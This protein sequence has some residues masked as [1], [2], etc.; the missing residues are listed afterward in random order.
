[1]VAQKQKEA[2]AAE[3]CIVITWQHGVSLLYALG[4]HSQGYSK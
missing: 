3:S 2:L 1:L 4:D